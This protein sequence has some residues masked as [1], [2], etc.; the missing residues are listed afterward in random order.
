MDKKELRKED[1]CSNC[2]NYFS[3][4]QIINHSEMIYV[5]SCEII[6]ELSNVGYPLKV[7]KY[8]NKKN[9]DD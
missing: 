4:L 6:G 5:S 2:K 3:D 9:K 8:F 7:C 1:L